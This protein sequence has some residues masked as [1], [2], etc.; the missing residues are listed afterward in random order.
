[1]YRKT[2]HFFH[3][4]V[5]VR[6]DCPT[7]ERVI[8][9]CGAHHIPFWDL[10]WLDEQVFTVITTLAGYRALRR[11]TGELPCT[12][13]LQR[14][15]GAPELLRR[16]RRRY[17]LLASAAVAAALLLH[18]STYLWAIEVTGNDTVPTEKIL[19]ALEAQGVTIGTRGLA[20]DQETLRNHVLLDLPE[21]S[22]LAVNISGCTAHVQVVERREAPPILSHSQPMNVVARRAGLV[23]KVQALDGQAAV[24]KGST[25][26]EGQLLI[27]GVVDSPRTGVRLLRGMGNVEARTWYD[28]S[29]QVP[30]TV[31]QRLETR[32]TARLALIFGKRRI[33]I[34]TRGS[35]LG[36]SCDKI[37]KNMP[38]S[39]PFGFRL[40][41]TLQTE[42]Y[43]RYDTAEA[44]RTRESAL[45]EAEAA[46][47][48]RLAA[49]MAESGTVVSTRFSSAERD[50]YLVVT[51]RA[52]CLEDIGVN[53]PLPITED[54]P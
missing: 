34:F 28:L 29:V 6:V 31:Q 22:W 54:T 3:G 19:R 33:N 52:E 8:N 7:P 17:A 27:S 49:E 4:Q 51:L 48:A 37:S 1:M 20:I 9:L 46:L 14:K 35:A 40:P 32:K 21:V 50:G 15:R 11:V 25:V 23:T 30:L 53:V 38:I 26:T 13:T 2:E 47:V 41:I 16:I 39:L 36:A 45:A 44:E 43:L 24:L 10:Q 42:T 5:T 12:V 18:G